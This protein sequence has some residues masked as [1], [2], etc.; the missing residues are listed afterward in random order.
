MHKATFRSILDDRM[1][2]DRLLAITRHSC[3]FRKMA[4]WSE[5][6]V[7]AISPLKLNS[8]LVVRIFG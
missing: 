8:V 3:R 4:E 7:V 6:H 5:D 1:A 2:R